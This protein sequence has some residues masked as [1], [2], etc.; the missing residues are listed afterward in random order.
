LWKTSPFPATDPWN[1]LAQDPV[2]ANY[3]MN[4]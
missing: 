2:H 4:F 3:F 1:P